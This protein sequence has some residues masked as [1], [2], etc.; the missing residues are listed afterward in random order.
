[1]RCRAVAIEIAGQKHVGGFGLGADG[2]DIVRAGQRSLEPP[3]NDDLA[4]DPAA[5]EA[6]SHTTP[7][8]A[9]NP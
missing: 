6:D 7:T 1:M 3:V 2:R 5:L 8:A 9:E 4:P